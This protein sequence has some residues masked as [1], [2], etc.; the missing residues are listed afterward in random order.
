MMTSSLSTCLVSDTFEWISIKFGIA[1]LHQ[2]CA[3]N[4]V[5]VLNGP[6]LSLAYFILSSNV[7]SS[8][9]SKTTNHTKELV[10]VING[11]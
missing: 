7:T 4:L 11:V 8:V 3:P 9:F 1:C 5:F 6:I 2:S 10:Y